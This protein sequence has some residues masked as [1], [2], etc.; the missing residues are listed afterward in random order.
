MCLLAR[1]MH[2][3]AITPARDV[4]HFTP[5]SNTTDRSHWLPERLSLL[6]VVPLWLSGP[7]DTDRMSLA[8]A[9]GEPRLVA[10]AV[11]GTVNLQRVVHWQKQDRQLFVP[12][13]FPRR[14]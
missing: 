7:T 3:Y 11:L 10:T 8:V 5:G 12:M 9:V 14:A 1:H 6:L 13:Q 4:P 2:M